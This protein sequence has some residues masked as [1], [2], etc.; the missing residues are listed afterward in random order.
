MNLVAYTEKNKLLFSMNL[1]L[2][3]TY[4]CYE[5]PTIQS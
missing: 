4:K 5:D 3:R 1:I 2:L